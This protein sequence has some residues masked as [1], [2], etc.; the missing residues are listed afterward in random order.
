MSDTINQD[1]T[2][3]APEMVGTHP[4]AGPLTVREKFTLVMFGVMI[5]GTAGCMVWLFLIR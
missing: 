3:E 5:L 1:E 2:V 4:D